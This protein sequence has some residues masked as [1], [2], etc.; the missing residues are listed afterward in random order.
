V[1]GRGHGVHAHQQQRLTRART[2][3]APAPPARAARHHSAMNDHRCCMSNAGS[4]SPRMA[5]HAARSAAS[6]AAAAPTHRPGRRGGARRCSSAAHM[7]T[8]NC[9]TRS[10]PNTCSAMAED[11]AAAQP[12]LRDYDRPGVAAGGHRPQLPQ[13]TAAAAAGRAAGTRRSTA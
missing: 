6:I 5:K 10:G 9:G 3:P 7:P 2:A 11:G 8:T 4:V 12:R 1:R 13:R